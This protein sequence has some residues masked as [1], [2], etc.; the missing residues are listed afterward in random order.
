MSS[1]GGNCSCGSNCNCRN[2]CGGCKMCPDLAG[3]TAVIVNL[4]AG[5]QKGNTEGFEMV[6]GFEGG[7]CDCTKCNC[8]NNCSCACCGCN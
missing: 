6:S 5:S 3:E 2:G 4:G 1:C 8:G 7:N